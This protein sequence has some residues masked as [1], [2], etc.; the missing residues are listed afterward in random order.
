MYELCK[1]PRDLYRIIGKALERGSL[2]GCSIDVSAEHTGSLP[3][4][5]D[6]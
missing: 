3:R 6:R 2:L 5:T 4:H 1:A